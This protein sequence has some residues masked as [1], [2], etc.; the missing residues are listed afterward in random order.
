LFEAYY[1]Y[2]RSCFAQGKWEKASDLFAKATTVNPDDYQA[3]GL[4]GLCF[5]ALDRTEDARGAFRD[6]LQ[7]AERHLQLHPDDVRAV[8]W[9]SGSLYGLQGYARALEWA[10]RALSM[11]PEEAVTLYNVS[12]TYALLK[13]ADKSINCLE[14]A[15][16]Q[17]F[18]HRE[19]IKNDP[20]LSYVRDH[21]RFRALMEGLSADRSESAL[22]RNLLRSARCAQR[23]IVGEPRCA[24]RYQMWIWEEMDEILGG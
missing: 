4:R 9:G 10:D 5:R 3:H 18:G 16:R 8:S 13:E 24:R 14:K 2:G 1:F 6:C 11:D 7:T 17:G 21:P 19:W 20:D 15:I 12:C 22:S 23:R